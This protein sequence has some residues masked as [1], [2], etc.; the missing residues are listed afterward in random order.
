MK[1]NKILVAVSAALAATAAS[2]APSV[3]LFGVLDT[4]IAYVNEHLNEGMH[5][6]V[7][8][9][10]ALRVDENGYVAKGAKNQSTAMGTG[11]VSTWGLKGREK[12]SDDVSVSFHLEQAF[13]ADTGE[14]YNTAK[15]FER[16]ASVGVESKTWG[17]VKLGRMPMLMTGSGTTGV[18][19]GRVNPFGAGWGNM[20]GGYK[21]LSGLAVVR[22]DNLLHYATPKMGGFQGFLQY[23]FGN[24]STGSD[25]NTSKV[26]R[27]LAGAV[28]YGSGR[29]FGALGVDWL[30]AKSSPTQSKDDSYRV[31]AGGHY[32]FDNWTAYATAHYLKNV[33]FI[34]GYS[35]REVAPMMR[36][37]TLNKGFEAYAVTA[38]ASFKALGGTVMTSAGYGWGKDQNLASKNKYQ[39]AN[40]GLGYRYSLSKRTMAYGIVGGF[41]ESADWEKSDIYSNEVILGL[42]HRF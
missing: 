7:G 40:A 34:G 3:E 12:L 9:R 24:T 4:G 19:N 39:R 32:T 15:A 38:G 5:A 23:N 22:L 25:E 2:A 41:W 14:D 30:N 20:T 1:M 42:M 36:G 27:Y 37:Q 33:D 21:F 17:T 35:T 18:F 13:L 28:T 8:Q 16:E 11:N 26:D 6:P 10:T 31:Y 29:W